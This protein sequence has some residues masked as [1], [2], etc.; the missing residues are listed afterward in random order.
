LGVLVFVH[1]F[2][3]FYSARKLGVSVD[4]F[5]FGFPPKLFSIRKKETIYSI[6]LIPF[7]GFV[8]LR[9]DQGETSGD[10]TSFTVQAAWK[11]LVI[12][13]SGVGMNIVLAAVLFSLVFAL[14]VPAVFGDSEIPDGGKLT[15]PQ[16]QILEVIDNSPST[17]IGLKT[18]DALVSLGGTAVTTVEQVHAITKQNGE[19]PIDIVIK[20]DNKDL[21]LVIT[22]KALDPDAQPS[23]GIAIAET[24]LITFP[25]Y[26]AL[27][28][29]PWYALRILGLIF[30]SL[31]DLV[32]NLF[33]QG[34]PSA[35]VS[36]PI[37]IAVLTGQVAHLGFVYIIQFA[38]LLSLS[39]AAM[40][41][42]PLPA[43]DGGRA[44][45]IILEK[46]RK[47]PVSQKIENTIHTIGFYVLI[48]LI[49]IISYRDLFKFGISEKIGN[50]FKHLGS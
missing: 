28:L 3:H 17:T 10:P 44:F 45:F 20:R 46:I 30:V 18:G 16:L 32:K 36:G 48:G 43:L 11:R 6:N 33:V 40:N 31:W 38:G 29:G 47:R 39:L 22:P 50:Y 34:G 12:L 5:G 27:W 8:R 49:L 42:L 41:V 2:G 26:K 14:G 24:G 25:W 4:E 9:G 21:A 37:G 35:D 19:K 15:N 23:L 1:E 13:L 7:G